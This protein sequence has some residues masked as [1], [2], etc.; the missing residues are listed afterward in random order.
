ML[1]VVVPL[2]HRH[3]VCDTRYD[4]ALDRSHQLHVHLGLLVQQRNSTDW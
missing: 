3:H 2:H 1:N 4:S